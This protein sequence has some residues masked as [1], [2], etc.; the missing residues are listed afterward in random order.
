MTRSTQR[1]PAGAAEKN[2]QAA[3][4]GPE[5]GSMTFRTDED[6]G[7]RYHWVIVADGGETLVRSE[8]F[9]SYEEANQAAGRVHRG[10]SHASF[11]DHSGAQSPV[12]LSARRAAASHDDSDAERWLD[13]GG[14]FSSEAV[15]R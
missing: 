9:G 12:D 10:A 11:E 1:K 3:T 8:G 4:P 15:T 14:S 6:N 13:E 7:G 2:L 5:P